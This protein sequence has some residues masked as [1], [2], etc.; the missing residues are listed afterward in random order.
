MSRRVAVV[1]VGALLSLVHAG[2]ARASGE[3]LVSNTDS[4]F[5]ETLAEPLFD[6]ALRW[7][8]GDVR[9]ATFYVRN[10]TRDPAG[11][12]LSLIDDA[13]GALLD[14]GALEMRVSSAGAPWSADP[15]GPARTM[16]SEVPLA[17]GTSAPVVVRVSFDPAASNRTQL[18]SSELRIRVRLAQGGHIDLEP[19]T[20][21][22]AHPAG[23]DAAPG[24]DG[25]PL[26]GTGLPAGLAWLFLLGSLSLGTGVALVTRRSHHHGDSDAL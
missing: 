5:A 22:G 25:G 23:P 24:P 19:G 8:P 21:P 16:R 17:A 18:L 2:P 1:V 10:T 6:P 4:G 20:A 14:S 12:S 13:A 3:V 11:L 26:P 7:V 9:S 15:R